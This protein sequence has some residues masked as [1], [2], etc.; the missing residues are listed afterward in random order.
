MAQNPPHSVI[1][2]WI[3]FTVHSQHPNGYKLVQTL[4]EMEP[5]EHMSCVV[6]INMHLAVLYVACL[7]VQ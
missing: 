1:I 3:A 6:E 2:I 5:V 4:N 7:L